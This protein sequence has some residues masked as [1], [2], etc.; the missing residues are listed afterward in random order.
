[1]T[2]ASTSGGAA[3]IRTFIYAVAAAVIAACAQTPADPV[4][5]KEVP[6]GRVVQASYLQPSADKVAVDVRRERTDNVIVQYRTVRLYIDG[7][8]VTDI[9]NAEHVQL[10]LSQGVHRLGV[11]TQFDPIKEIRFTVDAHYTNR[12]HITFDRDHRV[13][14]ARV[15]Q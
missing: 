13:S 3:V 2:K 9:D 8:F 1:M 10:Y 5:F 15:P 7:E 12:A 4:P 11:S 14:I 6:A